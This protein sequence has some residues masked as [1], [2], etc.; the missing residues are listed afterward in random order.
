MT[1]ENVGAGAGA[2]GAKSFG[3]GELKVSQ[4]RSFQQSNPSN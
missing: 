2:D 3:V 4:V 1:V